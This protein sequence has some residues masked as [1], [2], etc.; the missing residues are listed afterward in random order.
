[1]FKLRL[2][3]KTIRVNHIIPNSK[4]N[5]PGT[6]FTIWFQG[7]SIRCK[8]CWNKDTW[9]P[10][11]GKEITILNL[12]DQLYCCSNID[13]ITLTGG[14]PLDQLDQLLIFLSMVHKEH[15][16]FL[17]SG[18]TREIIE[19][20]NKNLLNY[21]DILCSG[22]FISELKSDKLGWRGSSNQKIDILTNRGK[23]QLK[24]GSKYRTEL[25]IDKKDASMIATGFSIPE[26]ILKQ[27]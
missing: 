5:G 6:R 10:N 18:Y 22:P 15:S 16:I 26:N 12:I 3:D 20:K 13:G 21:I 1:M 8:D 2:L 7:C 4:V 24:L 25:I 17:T 9:D 27:K 23:E 19:K 11:A 14:E